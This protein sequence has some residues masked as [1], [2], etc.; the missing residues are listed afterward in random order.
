MGASYSE[1]VLVPVL[2]LHVCPTVDVEMKA[3]EES[4]RLFLCIL[5]EVSLLFLLSF[6]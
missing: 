5:C 3:F 4:I 2:N 6:Y 1:T